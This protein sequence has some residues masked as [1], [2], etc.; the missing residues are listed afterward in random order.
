MNRLAD[1]DIVALVDAVVAAVDTDRSWELERI[2]D[3]LTPFG[4]AGLFT[5]ELRLNG[6]PSGERCGLCDTEDWL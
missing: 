2:A 5:E 4:G 1:R 6:T 3:A